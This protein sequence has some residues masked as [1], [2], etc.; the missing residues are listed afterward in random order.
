VEVQ[1]IVTTDVL[2]KIVQAAD[3]ESLQRALEENLKLYTIK[4]NPKV[5]FTSTDKFVFLGLYNLDGSYDVTKLLM[6]QSNKAIEWGRAL[7]EHYVGLS[8]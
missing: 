8:T 7:F 6:G 1:L 3:K 4:Q 5:A 2:E